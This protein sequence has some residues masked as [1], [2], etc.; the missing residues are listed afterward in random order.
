MLM[1]TCP[2]HVGVSM[3]DMAIR[4]GHNQYGKAETHLVRIMRDT[5]RHEIV[6]LNVT[7]SLRGDFAA[8]HTAGDQTKV[9]PTDT[10]KNTAYVWAKKHS[11]D[12]M[13]AYG[14]SLAR[15]FLTYEPVAQAR[16]EIERF[17]WSRATVDGEPHDHTF[18]RTGP[19]VRT[20]A[21]TSD[22]EASHVIQ[23]LKDLT[24]LKSTGS[25][26]KDFLVDQYTT[27]KPTNDRVMAT[28]L[29]A[30]WRITDPG[31][32]LDWNAVYDRVKRILVARFAT[33]ESLALQ[34]TLFEMGSA[35]LEEF[36]EIAEIRLSAPNKHHFDVDF[37][38]FDEDNRG[39]VFHADDR[40]YGLIQVTVERDDVASA[41]DAWVASAGLA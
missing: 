38:S 9:L 29:V 41:P 14:L 40:P 25:A 8:A 27:L 3:Y 16:I 23:G 17:A 35:V 13:E 4:L 24:L 39:E 15:H 22:T 5:P 36:P 31:D 6:D 32:G 33:V 26:F 28:S 19:E 7:T 1:E 37:S 34:Q 20:A 12:P 11:P 2:T 21:I 18:V 10:Q 30:R